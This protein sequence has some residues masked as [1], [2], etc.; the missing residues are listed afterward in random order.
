[1]ISNVL[2]GSHTCARSASIFRTAQDSSALRL[3]SPEMWAS[4]RRLFPGPSPFQPT[5][6]HRECRRGEASGVKYAESVSDCSSFGR[7]ERMMSIARRFFT[8]Q[9]AGV[10]NQNC[11]PPLFPPQ[12]HGMIYGGG[13]LAESGALR[14]HKLYRERSVMGNLH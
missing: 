10:C 7:R 11:N 1:M 2:S 14:H 6:F 4:I 9:E 5:L 12:I 13:G 8:P 3:L